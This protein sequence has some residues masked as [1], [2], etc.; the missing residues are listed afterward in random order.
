VNALGGLALATMAFRH[1]ED[2]A[3]SITLPASWVHANL[4]YPALEELEG[5][6]LGIKLHTQLSAALASLTKGFLHFGFRSGALV[7]PYSAET[8]RA[9]AALSGALGLPMGLAL[10]ADATRLAA[11][12]T[13]LAFLLHR[14]ILRLQISAARAMWNLLRGRWR[15]IRPGRPDVRSPEEFVV[16]HVIVGA[17]LLAPLLLLLPTVAL[18]AVV[19]GCVHLA[20]EV[21]PRALEASA[22]ALRSAPYYSMYH[23]LTRPGL[24]P[25]GVVLNAAPVKEPRAFRG[26]DALYCHHFVLSFRP[27]GLVAVLATAGAA[28][29]G[30]RIKLN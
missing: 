12:P 27:E 10:A 21:G 5:S 24:F 19:L 16:E 9:A 17:L 15:N 28:A 25:A 23:R 26:R 14:Q 13:T 2:I 22:G 20:M 6:P 11:V 8:V 30:E 4:L 7:A 18:H 1:A 3:A 29:P